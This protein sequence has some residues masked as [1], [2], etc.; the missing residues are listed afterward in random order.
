MI[1][2]NGMEVVFGKCVVDL[3]GGEGRHVSLEDY[4]H[5]WH[6]LLLQQQSRGVPLL[7]ARECPCR[8]IREES[9]E[10]NDKEKSLRL[11]FVC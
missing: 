5:G 10:H 8:V 2:F 9:T 4:G 7:H 3:V 1:K 6:E 11:F